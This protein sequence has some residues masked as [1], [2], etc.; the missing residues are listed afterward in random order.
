[1][2]ALQENVTVNARLRWSTQSTSISTTFD[3]ETLANLLSARLRA[4]LS[5]RPA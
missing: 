2:A 4:I 5:G 1:M 3:K